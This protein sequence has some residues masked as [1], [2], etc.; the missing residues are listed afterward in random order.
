MARCYFRR[1]AGFVLVLFAVAVCAVLISNKA[2][3]EPVYQAAS[4]DGALRIV[5]HDERCALAEITNLPRRATWTENGT[6]YEGCWGARPDQGIVLAYFSDK[7]VAAIPVQA[8][9]KVTGI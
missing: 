2:H 8:F 4:A 6:T 9:A 7:T 5:L 3:A 1:L